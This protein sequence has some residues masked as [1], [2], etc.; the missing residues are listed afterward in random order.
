MRSAKLAS[1]AG[2]ILTV[3]PTSGEDL[4][5]VHGPYLERKRGIRKE[6]ATEFTTE[7]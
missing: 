4:G 3:C 6:A 2:E 5:L 7:K 1:P